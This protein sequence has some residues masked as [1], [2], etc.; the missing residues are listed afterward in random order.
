MREE[1]DPRAWENDLKGGEGEGLLEG[2]EELD[3]NGGDS[4]SP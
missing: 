1:L 3:L 2:R 4:G